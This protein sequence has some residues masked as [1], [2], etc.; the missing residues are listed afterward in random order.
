MKMTS[1]M[2]KPMGFA[3]GMAMGVAAGA[4]MGMVVRPVTKRRRAVKAVRAVTK[5]AE[6]VA[7]SLLG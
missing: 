5:M 3:K 6:N 2:K 7:Q 4:V 1:M